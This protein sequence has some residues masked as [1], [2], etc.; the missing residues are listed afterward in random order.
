M[1]SARKG[2]DLSSAFPSLLNKLKTGLHS[3]PVFCAIKLNDCL[4]IEIKFYFKRILIKKRSYAHV[5][6]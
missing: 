3:N 5:L 6:C 4:K 1:S 2:S